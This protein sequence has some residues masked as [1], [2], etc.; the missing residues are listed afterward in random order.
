MSISSYSPFLIIISGVDS[1]LKQLHCLSFSRG[2]RHVESFLDP[3][4]SGVSP[5]SAL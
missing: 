3:L 4:K 5:V 2:N 1:L